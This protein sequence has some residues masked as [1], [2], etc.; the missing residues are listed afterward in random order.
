MTADSHG[1]PSNEHTRLLSQM[2]LP[3]T[4]ERDHRTTGSFG[5]YFSIDQS[6]H[7]SSAPPNGS[8]GLIDGVGVEGELVVDT[9]IHG[10]QEEEPK[11]PLARLWEQFE[12]LI[13]RPTFSIVGER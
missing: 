10:E 11:T 1:V 7:S 3:I 9:Q 2:S 5:G 12:F 8:V 13:M 6:E 4:T